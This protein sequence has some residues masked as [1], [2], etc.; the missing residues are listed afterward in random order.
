MNNNNLSP[1][2][3]IAEI[4]ARKDVRN[5][6][7]CP[8][9]RSAAL[10]IAMVRHPDI[11]TYS[12]SD[13]RSAG[14]IG[15]GMA[16]VTEKTVALICTS[17]TAAYNFAPS[18]AEAFFQEIPLLVLTAD[19]PPEW[20]HQYDG[21]TIYQKDI[22]GKHVKKSFELPSDYTNK[23][24][25]WQIERIVNEA[26]N[27]TQTSPKGPVHINVPIREPFY[28]AD[29]AE[30]SFDKNIRIVENVAIE[31]RLSKEFWQQFR[32]IW[33]DAER[34]IIVVGHRQSSVLNETLNKISEE[35]SIPVVGDIISNLNNYT[36]GVSSD[37]I[38]SGG[39]VADVFLSS[40]N[41]E[42]LNSLKP[43]LLITCGKSIISKNL[44]L[45]IRNNKPRYH[46]HVQEN[47]ELI[48]P[49]QTLTHKVEVSPEYFFKQLFEDLDFFKFKEGD[50]EDDESYFQNWQ[51]INST[52]KRQLNQ[53]LNNI[54][55]CEFK[56]I[57]MVLDKLPE[58]SIFHVANSMPVRYA[59][60]IGL[61]MGKNIE[62]F[63][64]RG[65]SGIDG[66]L[67]SAVGCAL[68]TDKMVTCLIGDMSFFYDRNAF[69]NTYLPDN[70]RVIV[71]NNHGGNIFK[72][73][74]GPNR[75]PEVDDY[76]TTKQVFS[77]QSTAQEAGLEYVKITT[78]NELTSILTQ[79][80]S[81]SNTERHTKA[82]L[83]EI[84]LDGDLNTK[85][86]AEYK[87]LVGGIKSTMFS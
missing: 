38:P 84:E 4:C 21:Q 29:N 44:K 65:T 74:D 17:G 62:V 23:D 32:E 52:A 12:I 14:F 18:V 61:E 72:I 53:F 37:S 19:R 33:Q 5:A 1:I 3:N 59:N 13:E 85:I 15:M 25:V 76:F 64:N 34:K 8:G 63:A 87:K 28:P 67:S 56:A 69:W 42:L 66:S 2:H 75:Q 36:G 86:F 82:K 16:Q 7:L 26:I 40:K 55:F 78:E 70:L 10:T 50:E 27:L 83:I 57:R 24:A 73:I 68:K 80:Y 60:L 30:I 22:F 47:G 45:F 20:I 11:E 58:N 6:I 54:E 43:D 81:K 31:K 9:S 39:I 35:F 77:A 51:W 41:E 46:F 49:F 71:L 79:F 48:D